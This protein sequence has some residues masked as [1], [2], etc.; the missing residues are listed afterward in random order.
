MWAHTYGIPVVGM[1]VHAGKAMSTVMWG[2]V[3]A[4]TFICMSNLQ[5]PTANGNCIGIGSIIIII[6]LVFH[7]KIWYGILEQ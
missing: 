4:G 1:V 2:V 7:I 5:T 6:V 3:G